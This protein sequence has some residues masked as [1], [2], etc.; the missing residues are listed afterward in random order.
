MFYI[1]S[2]S[3]TVIQS[4]WH[5]GFAATKGV[6]FLPEWRTRQTR[7]DKNKRK[8]RRR[9]M[10]EQRNCSATSKGAPRWKFEWKNSLKQRQAPQ[11]TA[12]RRIPLPRVIP[13]LFSEFVLH[14]KHNKQERATEPPVLPVLTHHSAFH[15]LQK[16]VF[17]SFIAELIGLKAG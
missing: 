7:T 17:S 5:A 9:K 8:K 16:P 15:T 12:S 11:T 1:H 13:A 2:C 6:L 10:T 3:A 4:I 14:A